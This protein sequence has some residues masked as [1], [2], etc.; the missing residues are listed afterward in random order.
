VENA[1]RVNRQGQAHIASTTSLST[2]IPCAT[3]PSRW[4]T[5][6]FIDPQPA[7]I[8]PTI[9][10]SI[11]FICPLLVDH[12]RIVRHPAIKNA[13]VGFASNSRGGFCPFRSP[14]H[15]DK[16]MSERTPSLVHFA[17]CTPLRG[18]RFVLQLGQTRQICPRIATIRQRCSRAVDSRESRA[19]KQL[20]QV[21]SVCRTT[22]A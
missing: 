4:R 18:S 10:I 1:T 8:S 14:H 12:G 11:V 7:S 6:V 15:N 3:A 21:A 9:N 5:S 2:S 13:S 20:V 16:V 17:P 22:I 19:H